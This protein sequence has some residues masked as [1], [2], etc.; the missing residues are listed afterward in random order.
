MKVKLIGEIRSSTLRWDNSGRGSFS[1]CA[2][3]WSGDEWSQPTIAEIPLPAAT[4]RTCGPGTGIE[5]ELTLVPQVPPKPI[6]EPIKIPPS[7]GTKPRRAAKRHGRG[8]LEKL[9]KGM[10]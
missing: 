10:K 1:V 8:G 5:I 7:L 6:M 2:T 4:H 9:R 3:I